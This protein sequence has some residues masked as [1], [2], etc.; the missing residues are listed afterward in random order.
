MRLIFSILILLISGNISAQRITGVVYNN[1][2]ERLPNA[3]VLIKGTTAGASANNNGEFIL[4]VRGGNYTLVCQYIGYAAVEKSISVTE[5][6]SVDFVLQPVE[7]S[8]EEVVIKN[9]E[10]PAYEII[11]QAI[12]KRNFYNTQV[13][14]FSMD[15]YSKDVIRT[16]KTPK[17]ILGNSLDPEEL[18]RSGIDST[19][20]GIIYLSETMSKVFRDPPNK[21]KV[22]VQ[23]SRVSGSNRFGVGFPTVI[24]L[25]TNNVK[26]FS[27]RFNPRGFISPIAD[28][29]IG[30][31]KFKYLGTFYENGKAIN[32]I[33]VTP[34][35]SYEPLFTGTINISDDDW[36]IHSFD[37]FVTKSAQLELLDTLSI[38]QLHVPVS[39][40]VWQPKSQVAGFAVTF[41]GFKFHGSFVNVF[42]SYNIAPQFDKKT[43]GN[44]ILKY[45]TTV[46]DK[47][48]NWW[49]TARPVPLQAD[50]L[51]DYKFK[52]SLFDVYNDSA[53]HRENRDSLRKWH[54]NIRPLRAI[55]P[56][57]IHRNHYGKDKSG[58][59]RWGLEPLLLN[60]E[61]NTVEG[62]AIS[63]IPYY[64]KNY[65]RNELLIEPVVRYGFYNDHL[66]PSLNI[67]LN[68]KQRGIDE[69][70]QDRSWLISGGKRVSQF[71]RDNPISP[72]VNTVSTLFYGQNY[73]KIYENYFGSLF[74]R[75][76]F[77]SGVEFK[78]GGVYEDR[79]PLEN[80][81]FYTVNKKDTQH[82]T[83]NYPF[84]KLVSNFLRHQA[85]VFEG[86]VSFQPGQRY[87][88]F[89]KSKRPIGSKYPTFTL[90]YSKGINGLLGSDVDF[91]KWNF[92]VH[93]TRNLKLLGT[94][95]Y[96]IGVGG[97]LND[98]TVPIQ[99]YIHFSGN[100]TSLLHKYVE[101]FQL[102]SYY[103][104]SN[105]ASFFI[106]SH[107]EH[108]FNGLI[109]NKIPL[110]NRLKW[111]L[112]GG[113]NAFYVNEKSNYVELFVGLENIFK[114]LRIDFIAAY[115]NGR[116]TLTGI[117]FGGGG[118]FG[119]RVRSQTSGRT[120]TSTLSAAF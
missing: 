20:K 108:H 43:F 86:E 107:L 41:L 89:P 58:D 97:F 21:V 100:L 28:G 61:Y 5:N 116:G 47:S 52:D 102:A 55:L 57:G 79:L 115:E 38:S 3:S 111:H 16:R 14:A 88:Q 63:L 51:L 72:L 33:R 73:M 114:V 13:D 99:D 30:F 1:K 26:V 118:I 84:E 62:L 96:R 76:K 39:D 68:R 24:S 110:F 70:Y 106:R 65:K 9:G 66:N 8:M 17:K 19:G 82:L 98:K 60:S 34:R 46:S 112:V 87:V 2:G 31:Y 83:P 94:M 54:G 11:R 71:N 49:D 59:F 103:A 75:K 81:T 37:L 77:E 50:E 113:G 105:T 48:R 7:L 120:R 29:A 90:K 64:I 22:E 53:K 12:K 91:D 23:S 15:C 101:S 78:V 92:E 109:T 95:V 45:D 119:D 32:S 74:F 18:K 67:E 6:I 104:N 85:T 80:N 42:S 36:R 10:D 25:Y 4:N 35:R 44:V 27:E 40:E 93:D 69:P 117:K 56:P